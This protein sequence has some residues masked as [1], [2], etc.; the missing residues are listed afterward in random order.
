VLFEAE[1]HADSGA[2][3]WKCVTSSY[4]DIRMLVPSCEY[5]GQAAP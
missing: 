1:T 5:T 2:V 3:T 4:R